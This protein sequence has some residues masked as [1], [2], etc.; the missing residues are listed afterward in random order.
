MIGFRAVLALALTALLVLAWHRLRSRPWRQSVQTTV[1]LLL[2]P[3]TLLLA[4]DGYALYLFTVGCVMPAGGFWQSTG[5][6]A[7]LLANTALAASSLRAWRDQQHMRRVVEALPH[8]DQD[9]ADRLALA[10][11][12]LRDVSVRVCPG[13][14]PVLFTT[15][16]RQPVI[17]V[18]EWVLAH[19]DE[20]ELVAAL[21]H[22]LGHVAHGDGPLLLL[23]HALCPAGLGV[24]QEPLRQLSVALEQRADAWA[25]A[26]H[27]DRLALASAL[28]KVSRFSLPGPAT[29]PA[30]AGQASSVQTRVQTLLA[31]DGPAR[32]PA[33]TE[34]WQLAAI[35]LGTLFLALQ[36]VGHLCGLHAV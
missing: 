36:A 8:L 33:W 3:A 19:L 18:S 15:G 14:Q 31:G 30:F 5:L 17:V 9:A 26:H 7:L 4:A 29:A 6:A 12:A 16:K 13:D 32:G 2:L 20:Q 35:G 21:A 11:P 25:A 28:V 23:V 10:L 24:F 22:E 34:W 27:A 1:G